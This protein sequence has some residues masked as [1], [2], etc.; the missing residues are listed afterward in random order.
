MTEAKSKGSTSDHVDAAKGFLT[1]QPMF[2]NSDFR[3]L[4]PIS[5]FNSSKWPHYEMKGFR[6]AKN[7]Q[8]LSKVT[9]VPFDKNFFNFADPDVFNAITDGTE[10]GLQIW[11]KTYGFDWADY[12]PGRGKASRH[13]KCNKHCLQAEFGK[14]AE[15]CRKEGGLFKCCTSL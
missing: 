9:E 12:V 10:N 2:K 6:A 7:N 5:G 11:K 13:Y 8:E 4:K 14:F 15:K 3:C 1:D